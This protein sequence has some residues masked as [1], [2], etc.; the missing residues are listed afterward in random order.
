MNNRDFIR[1]IGRQLGNLIGQA[2]LPADV[3]RKARALV[4]GGLSR[5]DVVTRE[6]FDAQAAVL[7]RTRARVDL[8]EQQLEELL[9][10]D[11]PQG[12]AAGANRPKPDA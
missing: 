9:V 10:R 8:L 3:E 5:M 2:D 7:A 12:D 11:T 4:Q 6:E 1:D